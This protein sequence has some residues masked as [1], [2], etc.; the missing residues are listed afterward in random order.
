MSKDIYVINTS[1]S[2]YAPL[3]PVALN[4]VKI[5]DTFWKPRLELLIKSTLPTQYKLIEE[6]GRLD[7][8][9]VASGKKKGS[10]KG[11]FWFNDSD[12]YKWI[13]AS[14]YAIVY[15]PS[16]ELKEMIDKAIKEIIDAQQDDGYIN[17]YV[18][19]N[20][21]ERWK[22]L[23]WSHEL[24]CAGHLF[25]AAVAVKRAL[26]RTDLYDS[27]LKFADLLY[28]TFGMNENKLKLADGHPEVEMALVELYRESEKKEYLELAD[29]FIN[30]RGY[31]KIAKARHN[32]I[33]L[34]DHKPLKELDDIVGSHA[35]RALYLF[36]GATDV[37]L[38]KGDRELWQALERLLTR[39]ISRKMY[40]TGGF[41]SRHE[42]ESFG[43]DYELP[44]DRAYSETCAAVAG[45]L[46]VWRMFLATGNAKYM[47][48]IEWVLYNAALASISLD[49][50]RYFYVNPLE[51]SGKHT[52]Q[53]WFECA[54]CPP[55]IA[56]LL[57][58]LPSLIYSIS[59]DSDKIWINLFVANEASLRLSNNDVK[60]LVDTKYPWDGDVT[61][62]V[63]PNKTDEFSIMVRIPSW[64][65]KAKVKINNEEMTVNK[66]GKY[67]EIK[68]TWSAG[69][70][71][72]L[73]IPME[74]KLLV[75]H[76]LVTNNYSK[77]AV[78]RGP[79]IYC[80]EGVDN[81]GIDPRE[82]IIDLDSADF[83]AKWYGDLLGG[84]VVI[85]GRGYVQNSKVFENNL[86][87]EYKEVG[88]NLVSHKEIV[89]TL[90]PYYAWNNRGANPM[91]VWIKA[92]S[93]KYP[94]YIVS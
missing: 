57:A 85:K 78:R 47:D 4:N 66:T 38:E 93:S 56:R 29:F 26:D 12:V 73:F 86:Y 6:T 1:K 64:A 50:K 40:V 31:G 81:P 51:D 20:K 70:I 84:V 30:I 22:D 39:I 41:G 34:V 7:N 77:V 25:Q 55:N 18:T 35:V 88:R 74:I 54:C 27:A 10:Y 65:S 24:Y 23:A 28:D 87:K 58:Y 68:R 94:L 8:F 80:A 17:T 89:F 91:T 79:L 3:V 13:E 49:G 2:P 53:P 71:I 45:I 9:R 21:M 82:I 32:P 61:I 46:W 69:D 15:Q 72:K 16:D 11:S 52:R 33:Y 60:L 36:A 67:V 48:I 90:I 62:T 43:E 75:S 19:I 76:P 5:R 92:C 63:F 59:K 37:Y 14:A 83:K 42:G 44:N